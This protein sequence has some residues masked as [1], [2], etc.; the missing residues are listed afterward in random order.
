MREALVSAVVLLSPI[1][2][3]IAEELWQAMGGSG[4]VLDQPWPEYDEA[5]LAVQE[6]RMAVQVNGKVRARL[7][8]PADIAEEQVKQAALADERVRK[9]LQGKSIKQFRVVPGRLISIVAE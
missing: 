3:H 2:P 9:H 5:A 8:L 6:V 7:T 4:S 1:V